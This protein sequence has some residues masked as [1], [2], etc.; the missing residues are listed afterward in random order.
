MT[1]KRRRGGF[2]GKWVL[3]ST[4]EDDSVDLL[5]SDRAVCKMESNS[6]PGPMEVQLEPLKG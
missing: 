1:I 5:Q 4:E 6:S 3:S 2:S